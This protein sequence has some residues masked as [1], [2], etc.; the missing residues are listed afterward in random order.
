M[1]VVLALLMFVVAILFS[2]LGQG[3]GVL[4]TPLQD[5]AGIEFQVAAATSLF[6][7]MVVSFSAS[8][9]FRKAKKIDWPLTIVLESA[10]IVGSFFGGL[11]SASWSGS[12]LRLLLAGVVVVAGVSMIRPLAAR[13]PSSEP[14]FTFWRRCEWNRRLGDEQYRVNL[15]LALPLSFLAGLVSGMVGVG[16]GVLKVP[17]MVL[18]FGIPMGIAIGSSALMIGLTASA[19]FAGH[20][21]NGH[22]DWKHSLVLAAAVFVGGQ[23]GSRISIRLNQQKLKPVFGCFL[24]CLALFMFLRM[25]T[26]D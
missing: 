17:M 22:W 12:S 26:G 9:V 7:I 2:M 14:G 6:L 25:F 1:L 19:G 8:L 11:S 5:W 24:L 16:G 18:L 15:A 23:I 20:L 13:V 21:V 4:Y 10:T 3:G